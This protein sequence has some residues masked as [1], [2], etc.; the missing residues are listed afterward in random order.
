M[1]HIMDDSDRTILAF[2]SNISG[3]RNELQELGIQNIEIVALRLERKLDDFIAS[4]FFP[5][6][7]V[8]V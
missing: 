4:L 6:V 2:K 7:P 8:G 1:Q 3:I 5:P